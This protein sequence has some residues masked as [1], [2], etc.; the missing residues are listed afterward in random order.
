MNQLI[1]WYSVLNRN[2]WCFK[3]QIKVYLYRIDAEQISIFLE[4]G[5]DEDSLITIRWGT[6]ITYD[7]IVWHAMFYTQCSAKSYFQEFSCQSINSIMRPTLLCYLI[8]IISCHSKLYHN[9]Q[10]NNSHHHTHLIYSNIIK[11]N[12]YEQF[13][14]R[15]IEGQSLYFHI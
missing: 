7:Q 11:L 13:Q 6:N 9:R 3:S 4:G 5:Q 10:Q 1:H 8:E 14:P 15:K 12:W 2:I